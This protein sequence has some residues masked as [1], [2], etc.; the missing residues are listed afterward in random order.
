MSEQIFKDNTY[1]VVFAERRDI[2]DEW[3]HVRWNKDHHQIGYHRLYML[4]SGR[5]A[6][7]LIDRTLDLVPGYVYFIPAFSVLQS[8]IDGEMNKYYIHFQADSPVF[9]LYRFLSE[10]Y[11]VKS[12]EMTEYLFN[13]VVN[14]YAKNTQDA[15]LKVRGAMDLLLADFFSEPYAHPLALNKFDAVLRHI[16]NNFSRNIPLSE[17]ASI[18]NISTMYFSNYFKQVFHISPKQYILHKRLTESQRLLLETDM[19]VKEIAYAVGFENESYFSEFFSAKTG[20][21]AR[22]FRNRELP[23][24]RASVL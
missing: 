14:N 6:I 8:E 19:S 18:M 22:K 7:H 23:R 24:T 16:D 10:R 11:A 9:G 1:S 20:I 21:S 13:T 2:G 5:A 12:D 4:T 17:L 3:N 15:Y